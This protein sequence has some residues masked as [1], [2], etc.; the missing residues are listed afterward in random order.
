MNKL[1]VAPQVIGSWKRLGAT[2][3]V[4]LEH[5][6]RALPRQIKMTATLVPGHVCAQAEGTRSASNI[7][8]LVT[9]VVYL[10]EVFPTRGQSCAWE[11]S[12]V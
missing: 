11:T 8:A 5:A 4:A 7:R 6:L 2:G 3:K 9:A 1:H 12:A 10:L